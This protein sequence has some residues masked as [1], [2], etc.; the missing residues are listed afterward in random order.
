VCGGA[1]GDPAGAVVVGIEGGGVF[2]IA[3]RGVCI[4]VMEGRLSD[5]GLVDG[6]YRNEPIGDFLFRVDPDA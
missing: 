3:H 2:D 1:I 6:V 4:S 5:H